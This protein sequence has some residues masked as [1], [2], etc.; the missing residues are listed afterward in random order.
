LCVEE[1]RAEGAEEELVAVVAKA[2]DECRQGSQKRL[3]L[4]QVLRPHALVA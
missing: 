1:R 3:G 2:L 4:L